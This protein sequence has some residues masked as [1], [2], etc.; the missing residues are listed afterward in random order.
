VVALE[1][2]AFGEGLEKGV[3][4]AYGT[5]AGGYAWTENQAQGLDYMVR[6]GMRPM[7]AIRSATSLAASLL[8]RADDLGSVAPGHCSDPIATDGDPPAGIKKRQRAS[9]VMNGGKIYK[10]EGTNWE[11]V[12]REWR[13]GTGPSPLP[14]SFSLLLSPTPPP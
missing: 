9:W 6:Y 13:G 3:R 1:R 5:D 2:K 7:Q 11:E 12:G 14:S 8:D 4:I 10:G